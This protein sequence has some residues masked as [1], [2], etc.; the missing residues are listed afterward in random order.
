MPKHSADPEEMKAVLKVYYDNGGWLDNAIFITGLK[1]LIGAGL[2]S[3]AYTKKTQIPAYFGFITWEDLS[4]PQS[5]RKIT[6]EGKRFY[7]GLLN[8]NDDAIFEEILLS[9]ENNTFGRNVCGC[10][11]DTNIEPPQLFIRCALILGFLTRKEYGYILWRSA[12]F[13]EDIF[14]L[15]TLVSKNRNIG[16]LSYPDNPSGCDDAKPITALI[17]WGFLQAQAERINGQEKIEINN[18]VLER[19]RD[20]LYQLNI[21]NNARQELNLEDIGDLIIKNKYPTGQNIIY[22]GAPGTGKSYRVNK[23]IE[24][25]SEKQFERITF[26]PEYDYNSFV[27]CYKPIMEK[28]PDSDNEE[29]KYK[30]TPEAFTNIYTKAWNSKAKG[31]EIDYCLII[32]EI[33]RGN[34]AEIFGDIFQLLDRTSDYPI[35][36]SKELN[37]HLEDA[38]HAPNSYG[39]EDGKLKLPANLYILA[40]MNTSD[41]SLLPMD[42]AFKR[43]WEWEYIPINYDLTYIDADGTENENI[44]YK[45]KVKL[46]G[47]EAFSWLEFIKKINNNLISNNP[48]LG[49]DKCLGNYFIKPNEAG[50]IELEA[51]VNKAVF[52]LWNDV[53][54]DQPEDL[55]IFKDNITY[56]SFFPIHTN[57]KEKVKELLGQLEINTTEPIAEE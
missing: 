46:S 43:R 24:D 18:E 29:I 15:L 47:E 8:G 51:F 55:N 33:N 32:E 38:L 2:E 54:K 39:L 25:L 22:Y 45:Y 6:E 17:K 5:R 53:F 23:I 44:S 3:Q 41:Q 28:D 11:S 48:D 16:D 9:L 56:E 4:N 12:E 49:M 10:S 30:F 27:G 7:E 31:E 35:T 21:F 14:G 42:S 50:I 26:H 57:G 40:T 19:H 34:C 13:D 37:E 1:Q 20:R 52:Y 36:P